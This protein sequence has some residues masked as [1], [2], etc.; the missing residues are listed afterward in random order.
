MTDASKLGLGCVIEQEFEDGRHPI[1]YASR[2]LNRDEKKWA[3]R[4]LEAL[5]IIWALE[6]HR[7]LI[8]QTHF[9]VET[10]H[11]SLQWLLESNGPGRIGRWALR[12]QEFKP[13]MTI[14]YRPGVDNKVADALS[15]CPL[16]QKGVSELCMCT[17]SPL[18][19]IRG[20]PSKGV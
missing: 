5:A 17:V 20:L 15:R 10:D 8:D 1:R 3:V 12:L 7:V 4:E 13:F 19:T 11:G 6:E 9:V 16:H 14:K 2:S 18:E